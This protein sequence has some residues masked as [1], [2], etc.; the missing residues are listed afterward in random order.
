MRSILKA[1]SPDILQQLA[2]FEQDTAAREKI[3]QVVRTIISEVREKGD[4]ALIEMTGRFDKAQI[5]S[6]SIRVSEAEL[7]EGLAS[8]SSDDI[9][10]IH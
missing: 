9:G 6:G 3:S 8:L 10:N 2:A 7:D 1:N 4:K 5:S